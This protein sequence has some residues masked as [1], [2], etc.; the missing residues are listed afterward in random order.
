[1]A[2]VLYEPTFVIVA[3]WFRRD[4]NK[5]LAVLTFT[6]GL[7]S[8]VF[9]PLTTWLVAQTGW[10]DALVI[11]AIILA[12]ATILPHWF[13]IRRQPADLGLRPDGAPEIAVVHD[14]R[15]AE[16]V[17]TP[18]Q[19]VATGPAVTLHDALR[20]VQ[21]WWISSSFAVIWGC[22]VA[23]QIHLIPYLQDVGF[24]AAFAATAAGAIG[25]FKLPGRII[26]APLAD[27]LGHRLLS[28]LVFATHAAAIAVLAMSHSLVGVW[29]FVI[30]FS[31]GNGTLTLM[32]A[33][34]V[35]D[36]FGLR[37]YGA[38][39]GTTAFVSQ[40]AMAAGPLAVSLLVAWWGG[41]TPVFWTLSIMV[42]LSAIGVAQVRQ[43]TPTHHQA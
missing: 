15:A 18:D 12:I 8:V 16:S 4:R 7:A 6:G 43:V 10:R 39:S 29:V 40:A 20:T 30:L 36:V 11:L 26:F 32:R 23:V 14:S 1:M 25:L 27:R 22:A 9:L 24:S 38:I 35:V 37:S 33:S 13:F 42:A 19:A 28:I 3:T 31:A 34:L 5:A 2:A 21:F 41:Y 17:P